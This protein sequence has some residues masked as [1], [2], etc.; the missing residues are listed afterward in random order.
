MTEVLRKFNA[1]K[2]QVLDNEQMQEVHSASLTILEDVGTLVHHD[3]A[4]DLL[5]KAGAYVEEGNR[6]YL[7]GS[8]VEWAIRTAP[9][10]IAIYDRKGI[11]AMYLEGY[12]SYF[13][14]GSDCPSILD[15]FTGEKRRFLYKDV[16]HAVTLCDYLSNI[17]FIMSMGLISD[18]KKEVSY[19]HEYAV[20]IRN[21]TKPQT[22]TAA[23]RASLDDIAEMAAAVVGG[24]EI[25]SRKPIFVLYDEPSSPLQHSFTANK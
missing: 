20:M 19:Q 4:I 10:R 13:G 8:L 6:V 11:P 2:F 18:V 25:L 15:S 21:S 9:S 7:P 22:I 3:E 24:R 14:T 17:D 1:T 16:E 23:D 5:K 12:N